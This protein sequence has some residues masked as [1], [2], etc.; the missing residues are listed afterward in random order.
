MSQF[1]SEAGLIAAKHTATAWKTCEEF[2][3]MFHQVFVREH[4]LLLNLDKS[5]GH[6]S[7]RSWCT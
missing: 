5:G 4:V 6:P 2:A 7:G 3:G 1:D